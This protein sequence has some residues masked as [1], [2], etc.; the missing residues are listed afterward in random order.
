[1][2]HTMSYH[3]P[4]KSPSTPASS[5]AKIYALPD[6]SQMKQWPRLLRFLDA[7]KSPPPT[8]GEIMSWKVEG[9]EWVK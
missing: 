7:F 2:T 4:V 6:S 5:P 8:S 3:K 9:E 1:M